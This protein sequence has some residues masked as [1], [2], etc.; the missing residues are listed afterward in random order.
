MASLEFF[1]ADQRQDFLP[2]TEAPCM[3]RCADC[4]AHFWC[5]ES[6]NVPLNNLGKVVFAECSAPRG[7]D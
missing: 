4:H 7:L 5:D 1:V 6:A 2:Y 3:H